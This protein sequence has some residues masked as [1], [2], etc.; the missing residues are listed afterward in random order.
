MGSQQ[1][2]RGSKEGEEGWEPSWGTESRAKV[3]GTR[4]CVWRVGS[5]HE[6]RIT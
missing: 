2:G 3:I 1:R 4:G 6:D 5:D